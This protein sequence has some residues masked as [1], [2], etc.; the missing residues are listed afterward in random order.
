MRDGVDGVRLHIVELQSAVDILVNLAD[1]TDVVPP[2]NVE[3]QHDLQY[4]NLTIHLPASQPLT[5]DLL[6][7]LPGT[8][9][10]LVGLVQY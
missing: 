8:V 5:T 9:D 6:Y 3:P 7:S 10:T 1:D 4:S 2:D